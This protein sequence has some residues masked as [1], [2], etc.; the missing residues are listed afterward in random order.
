MLS[1]L[2]VGEQ[3]SI[4]LASVAIVSLEAFSL[5]NSGN[6]AFIALKLMHWKCIAVNL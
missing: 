6:H 5:L 3:W 1:H 4:L 2:C